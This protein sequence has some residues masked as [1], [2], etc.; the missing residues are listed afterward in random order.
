ME[1]YPESPSSLRV[2]V[3]V[4]GQYEKAVNTDNL[5]IVVSPS[6]QNTD[7]AELAERRLQIPRERLLR[8]DVNS[9]D[10]HRAWAGL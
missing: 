4:L 1:E 3:G 6:L 10:E 9:L 5:Q 8:P 7:Y 2:D